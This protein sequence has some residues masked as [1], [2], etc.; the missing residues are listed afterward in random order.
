MTDVKRP[1]LQVQPRYEFR[2]E[3]DILASSE[4]LTYE[5]LDF[6]MPPALIESGLFEEYL[7]WYSSCGRTTSVHGFFMDVNPACSDPGIRELSKERCRKSCETAVACG[8]KNVVFHSSCFPFLRGIYLDV[9]TSR[10]T[11]F[12]LELAETYD[13]NIYI[14]NSP[15]VDPGPIKALMKRVNDKRIGVC[16]DLGHAHY[17]RVPVREWFA[18]LGEWIGYLHLSDNMGSYDDHLLLGE[19]SIDWEEADR[20]WRELDRD[21]VITLEVGGFVA[22]GYAVKFLKKNGY[23]GQSNG[24]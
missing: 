12:Y 1:V 13:L 11:D 18:E 17:S 24:E 19:G 6:S 10:C 5:A 16:L 3:W 4:G 15:D 14:E 2:E 22:S 9:W 23:F 7:D 8:A 21:T 20:L